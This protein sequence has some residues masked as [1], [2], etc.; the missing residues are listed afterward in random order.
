M[1][2]SFT[3]K[4]GEEKGFANIKLTENGLK[5]LMAY[6]WPGNVRELQNLIERLATL[7]PGESID[8]DVV[9]MSLGKRKN[10]SQASV[11]EVGHSM[12]EVEKEYILR[13]LENQGLN[14]IKTAEML[15]IGERTLR[16]KLKKWKDAGEIDI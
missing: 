13:T 3:K 16:E 6:Q 4:F 14:R 10:S 9:K 2:N 12:A 11:F 1:I 7:Y 15:G 8:E 5:T